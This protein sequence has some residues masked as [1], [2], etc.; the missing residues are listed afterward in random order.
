MVR[1]SV[2][3]WKIIDEPNGTKNPLYIMRTRDNA[4]QHFSILHD[5]RHSQSQCFDSGE[6]I[7]GADRRNPPGDISRKS[8]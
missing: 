2:C 7:Q 5:L 6:P 1:I 3:V 4:D 8:D